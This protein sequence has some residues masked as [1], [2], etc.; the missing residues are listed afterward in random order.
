MR[1]TLN[2]AALFD[3]LRSTYWF[4][5]ALVT[6]VAVLLA[7]GILAI[8]R[9]HSDATELLGWLYGGGAEGA[10]ALLSAVAGS[11]MTVV[12]VTFS[13]MVVALTVSSQHFGPRL[14]NSF[15]RDNASQLVLGTFTGTFAFCL[16][17]LR[18][19][20][21]EGDGYDTFVP[22]MAVTTAVVLALLSVGVLIYYVHHIA[23]SMQVAEITAAV[24]SDLERAIERLYPETIGDE[25]EGE[26]VAPP[27]P[28]GSLFVSAPASG[29][30]QQLDEARLFRAAAEQETCLWLLVRPG[31]FLLHG[32]PLAAAHPRPKD[33]DALRS[34]LAAACIVGNDRTAYQDADFAVQQLVEVGLRA[35]SP[36]VNEPLTAVTAIDRLHQG[37]AKLAGRRIPHPVR[38]GEDG[39]PRAI[40]RP[41]TFVELVESAY[42]PFVVF[43]ERNTVVAERLLGVLEALAR[44]VRRPDDRA[45][46]ER[47]AD[48][49]ADSAGEHLRDER[50]RGRIQA[51][52]RAVHETNVRV[53]VRD[54]GDR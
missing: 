38:T 40:A 50:A 24:A 37:L 4:L 11:T 43:I 2:P 33:P 27:L 12:S 30:L 54:A 42:E 21:G 17:V 39:I 23:T 1:P 13:V 32:A 34:S 31:E 29:Y 47:L 15:M 8:D 28:T 19:V 20:R 26:D 5:P 44:R 49:T 46:L 9:R 41:R 18:T 16:V 22:H 3:R 14:L 52:Q 7:L 6:G 48:L 53:A 45:A 25:G 36:G 35:L 10:R 51:L